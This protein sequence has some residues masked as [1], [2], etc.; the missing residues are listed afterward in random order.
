MG[1]TVAP[2]GRKKYERDRHQIRFVDMICLTGSLLGAPT[3]FFRHFV[4]DACPRKPH[5]LGKR[6]VR[7]A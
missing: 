3:M 1:Q 6:C 2:A 5:K 4:G 7:P